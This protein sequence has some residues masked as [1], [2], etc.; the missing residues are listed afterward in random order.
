MCSACGPSR[1]LVVGS[2][3]EGGEIT[4]PIVVDPLGLAGIHKRLCGGKAG[5]FGVRGWDLPN[6]AAAQVLR[7][8]EDHLL[9]GEGI[10]GGQAMRPSPLVLEVAEV[11]AV[12]RLADAAADG[13]SVEVELDGE[14]GL[15]HAVLVIGPEPL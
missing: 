7:L 12:E 5:R 15:H 11:A 8:G 4:S 9:I 1:R 3:T 2:Y 13:A 14:G 6:R 10:A